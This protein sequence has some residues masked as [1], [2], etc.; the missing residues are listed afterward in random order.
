VL[1]DVAGAL[2]T[3]GIV[4]FGGV[5]GEPKPIPRSLTGAENKEAAN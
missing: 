4:L 3:I 1:L 2:L 5:S